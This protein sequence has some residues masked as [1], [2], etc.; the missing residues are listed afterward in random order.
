MVS[1]ST[2]VTNRIDAVNSFDLE[3]LIYFKTTV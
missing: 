1:D 3:M 2:N